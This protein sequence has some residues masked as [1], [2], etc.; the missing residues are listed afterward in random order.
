[1]S[2]EK[3][4]KF[5]SQSEAHEK[6]KR[7]CAYQERCQSEVRYKLLEWGQR[8]NTLENI[9]ADLISEDFINEERFARAYARGKFR[10][11]KWGTEKIIS[12]LRQRNI[13]EYCIKKALLEIDPN[14]LKQTLQLLI[15][16]KNKLIKEKNPFKRNQKIASYI[17]RKGYPTDLV[18][19]LLKVSD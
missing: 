14:D 15:D 3:K 19:S 17:I 4:I 10:M 18:W 7:Y 11:K 1:M 8:G 9:I 2:A 12:E 16:K 13:S 5:Y 6:A